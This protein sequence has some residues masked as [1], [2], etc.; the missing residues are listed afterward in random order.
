MQMKKTITPVIRIRNNHTKKTSPG[1][2][3]VSSK[4]AS[5]GEAGLSAR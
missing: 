5:S 4:I 1:V 3:G 2:S